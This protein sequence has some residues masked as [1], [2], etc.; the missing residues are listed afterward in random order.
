MNVKSNNSVVLT[1]ATNFQ[2]K[3]SSSYGE[4]EDGKRNYQ[5]SEL[6]PA[7]ENV[8]I[9]SPGHDIASD[10][11][12]QQNKKIKLE[13]VV[14]QYTVEMVTKDLHNAEDDQCTLTS[15]DRLLE[16]VNKRI[17][18]DDKIDKC[19]TLN[20]LK[21]KLKQHNLSLIQY[22][23]FYRLLPLPIE[24]HCD[25]GKQN[26]YALPV[27]S[28]YSKHHPDK[29][30]AGATINYLKELSC[31]F[32]DQTVFY[33][34]IEKACVQFDELQSPFLERFD[35]ECDNK[36]VPLI[37]SAC[38]IDLDSEQVTSNGPTFVT[39]SPRLQ[40]SMIDIQNDFQTLIHLNEFQSFVKTNDRRIKP[41]LIL[42]SDGGLDPKS[43]QT[44][45]ITINLF[46]KFNLDCLF[47][48]KNVPDCLVLNDL[49]SRMLLLS[50]QLSGQCLTEIWNA[51]SID[52]HEVIARYENKTTADECI[53]TTTDSEWYTTHVRQ[54]EYLL[55]II[56]CSDTNC[57]KWDTNYIDM[58]SQRF[59]PA[60]VKCN[61]GSYLRHF[62]LGDKLTVTKHLFV[63]RVVPVDDDKNGRFA[64]LCERLVL[65]HLI[66]KLDNGEISYDSYCPSLR[67][68]K[69][70]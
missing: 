56:K 69:T 17:T 5:D 8:N 66:P 63:G 25:D 10:D 33:L 14:P 36:I 55:Q 19:F 53:P 41:I 44:V 40:N 11:K 64:N 28:K 16:L 15:L 32:G 18:C 43:L 9:H 26:I 2:R 24:V 35:S 20:D 68:T 21:D 7:D 65:D 1:E 47:V 39:I 4:K 29:A 61:L 52:G 51:T 54:S 30:F 38:S 31:I 60:P 70:G 3:N 22:D 58:F 46:K 59:L 37:Y 27:D 49:E 50:K 62:T 45:S 13:A 6:S 23:T 48:I 34:N 12:L 42:A 57:C 67:N